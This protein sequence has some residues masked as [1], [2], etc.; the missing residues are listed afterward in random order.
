MHSVTRKQHPCP[1]NTRRWWFLVI[2]HCLDK[3]WGGRPHVYPCTWTISLRLIPPLSGAM[4]EPTPVPHPLTTAWTRSMPG[5]PCSPSHSRC[6]A[7]GE[8][9][10]EGGTTA[11]GSPS[12]AL[13][14]LFRHQGSGPPGA[15]ETD[16][17]EVCRGPHRS[18]S[19]V[20]CRDVVE[21]LAT[22]VGGGLTPPAP[23]PPHP[24]PGPRFHR[25]GK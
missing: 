18:L 10:I 16:N 17:S 23:G 15:W 24:P 25:G 9:P 13:Q 2:Y 8:Q 21:R 7:G 1:G 22:V 4:P 12:T 5:A 3:G 6:V 19:P 14:P 20:S 11:A